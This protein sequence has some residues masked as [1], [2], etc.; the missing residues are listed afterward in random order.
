MTFENY[1]VKDNAQ[2]QLLVGIS[3]IETNIVLKS[4]Q[5]WRF[6]STFPSI[7]T[8]EKVDENDVVIQR[9]KVLCTNKSWD[10]LV[11]TRWF[12]WDIPLV[13]DVDDFCSL[14][15]TSAKEKDQ[16]DEIVR[17]ETAKLNKS[18]ALRT[19]LTASRILH[20]D[21]SGNEAWLAL[22]TDWQVLYSNL[23]WSA[24]TTDIN[25]LD[26]DD[27]LTASTDKLVFYDA[28]ASVN[29][30]RTAMASETI[31]WLVK[32]ATN[33]QAIAR[34][35]TTSYL[36]PSHLPLVSTLLCN[37]VIYTF[38]WSSSVLA[39]INIAH[40]LWR[41]PRGAI[42][43]FEWGGSIAWR[44]WWMMSY[45]WTTIVQKCWN[46]QTDAYEDYF[47]W[48]SPWG[49]SNWNKWTITAITTTNV[50]LSHSE[51]WSIGTSSNPAQIL[52]YA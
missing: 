11:V 22:G 43:R 25:W 32:K 28:S 46:D 29:K 20:T 30:K 41:I 33:A 9:E 37:V 19:W 16:D 13:F 38:N 14:Y 39:N 47:A 3:A 7:L 49:S 34:T 50:T 48:F 24:P 35:D 4:G 27:T 26:N 36:T 23:T 31:H 10:T 18:W 21:W 12:D 6:P 44:T 42:V 2:W 51:W 5:W 8:L 15:V 52:F 17:L 40:W 1:K 45:D